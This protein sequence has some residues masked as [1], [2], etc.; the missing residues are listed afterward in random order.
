MKALAKTLVVL[1]A[2]GVFV[3]RAGVTV[4]A[5]LQRPLE[6]ITHVGFGTD[7]A[8]AEFSPLEVGR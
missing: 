1:T 8:V 2:V 4:D 5:K 6:S 3:G 7:S